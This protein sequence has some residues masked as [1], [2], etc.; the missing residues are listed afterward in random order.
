MVNVCTIVTWDL[1]EMISS[2][3]VKSLIGHSVHWK[4]FLCCARV[5]ER[6]LLPEMVQSP[7]QL[8]RW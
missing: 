5:V 7:S 1:P 8:E 4:N 3:V 6:P 2:K